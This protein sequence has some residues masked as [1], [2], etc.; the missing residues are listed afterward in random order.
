M[1]I[2]NSIRVCPE[3][4]ADEKPRV[5]KVTLHCRRFCAESQPRRRLRRIIRNI[6]RHRILQPQ[7]R[8]S[9]L[10]RT[11]FFAKC[12]QPELLVML[13][14]LSGNLVKDCLR[15]HCVFAGVFAY[16]GAVKGY[17]S[18]LGGVDFL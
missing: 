15:L 13:L 11:G 7:K 18:T 14:E 9:V 17:N 5:R 6:Y 4:K 2:L 8:V 10:T 1:R 12:R 16:I 3:R